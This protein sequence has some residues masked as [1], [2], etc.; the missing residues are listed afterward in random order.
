MAV[1]GFAGFGFVVAHLAGNLQF[2]LGPEALN[3]YGA[4]LRENPALLLAA[5]SVLL[6]AVVLHIVTAFQLW[7]VNRRARPR[8][9]ARWKPQGSTYAARTMVLS[10]PALFFFLLYH[11]AHL[12][13]GQAHPD[14]RH[15]AAGLPDVY[16]NVVA[17]FSEPL[18]VAAYIAAM[19]FLGL[20]LMHGIWSAF[21]SLGW[22]HPRYMPLI[23][24][25]AMAAA[26][27]IVLGN[28]SIP[29]SVLL[30]VVR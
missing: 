8:G 2:F 14:F 23:R 7:R 3:G 26:A 19:V 20:H 29:L 21:Q 27:A 1:T 16:H 4:K 10:G 30:G 11:L 12:T 9:Y 13:W 17:G 28:I 24:G 5:R 18:A 25:A 6:A 22:N 15:D